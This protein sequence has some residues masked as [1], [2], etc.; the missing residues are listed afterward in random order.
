LNKDQ[1]SL[2]SGNKIIEIDDENLID[3][4]SIQ[5]NSEYQDLKPAS[6]PSP[7][8]IIEKPLV[9]DFQRNNDYYQT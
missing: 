9:K 6:P 4:K 7:P 8:Q 2:K 5:I 3:S 1:E